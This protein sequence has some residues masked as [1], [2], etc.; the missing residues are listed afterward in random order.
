LT[1]AAESTSEDEAGEPATASRGD[2]GPSFRP[3]VGLL[4]T[5]ELIWLSAI[6]YA[7][8]LVLS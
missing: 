1:T 2:D 8:S 7:L 4:I 5:V 3:L 6:G